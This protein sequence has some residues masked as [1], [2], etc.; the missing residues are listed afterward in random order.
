MIQNFCYLCTK[1]QKLFII[2]IQLNGDFTGYCKS[3]IVMSG[4]R[5]CVN[6]CTVPSLDFKI[7]GTYI[8][9]KI[10]NVFSDNE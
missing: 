5:R 10:I 1:F 9:G 7:D 2:H 3:F 6:S 4:N 8:T